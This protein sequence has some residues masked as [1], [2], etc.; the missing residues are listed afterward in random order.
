MHAQFFHQL[1]LAGN[2]VQIT[3]QQKK[4]RWL[5][6]GAHLGPLNCE[7]RLLISFLPKAPPVQTPR[8]H[9]NRPEQQDLKCFP[10]TLPWVAPPELCGSQTSSDK[11]PHASCVL[12]AKLGSN[13]RASR[14][15]AIASSFFRDTYKDP[16]RL[17][18]NRQG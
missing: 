14:H 10:Q 12:L 5:V 11:P 13:S 16:S 2:A 3:D 6:R 1:P 15:L 17:Y 8:P 4:S 9:R 7:S 18:A